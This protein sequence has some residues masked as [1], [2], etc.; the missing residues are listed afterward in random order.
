VPPTLSCEN[1][2]ERLAS[3]RCPS[4][5]RPICSEC[6]IKIEGINVCTSCLKARAR[7]EERKARPRKAAGRLGSAAGV[8]AG[9][10]GLTAIYFLYGMLL[11]SI[12]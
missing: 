6:T 2:P 7:T 10:F 8:V 9:M 3:A 1:H 12:L 4:C 11:A 5:S